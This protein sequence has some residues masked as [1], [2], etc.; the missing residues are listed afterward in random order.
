MCLL[1]INPRSNQI[2]HSVSN[3]PSH[4]ARK[5]DVKAALLSL[6]NAYEISDELFVLPSYDNN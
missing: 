1:S 5:V 3:S 6:K 2:G 4:K